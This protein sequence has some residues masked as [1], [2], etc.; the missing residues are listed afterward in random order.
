MIHEHM[1]CRYG[2]TQSDEDITC[3][4][5]AQRMEQQR[6]KGAPCFEGG[7]GGRGPWVGAA[8]AAPASGEAQN[9][10]LDRIPRSGA[11]RGRQV[12]KLNQ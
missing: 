6:A 9:Y 2:T 11:A 1:W 10:F 8:A 7:A 3:G 12:K 4:I 5:R